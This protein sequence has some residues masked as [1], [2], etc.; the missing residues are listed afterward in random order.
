MM[1]GP[2][3]AWASGVVVLAA[4]TI[5]SAG[6]MTHGF[7][8]YYAAAKLLVSGQLGPSAYDDRWF[9]AYVQ[10]VTHSNVREIF[11]PN[12]PPMSLMALPVAA[13]DAG[14]ARAAWLSGSL[15]AFAAAMWALMRWCA[16]TGRQLSIVTV[17]VMML[18]PAVFTNLRIGQGYLLVCALLV[19]AVICL[20]RGRDT[21]G[22]VLLGALLALKTSGGAL[23]VMLAARQRWRAIAFA[24]ITALAIAV[25]VTPWIDPQMWLV[26]PDHVRAYVAR[27]ASS[28]TAYQTTL[29]L[30]R[31]VCVADP[32]WNP[33]P[34]ASCAPVAFIIPTLMVGAATLATAIAAYRSRST[35]AWLAAGAVLSVLTLPA[36]AEPHFVLMAIPL[37]LLALG[38]I[39]FAVVATLL[40]V[41]LEFTA[42]RF[43]AGWSVLLAYPRLYAAWLL[44]AACVKELLRTAGR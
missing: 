26:Y 18:S 7:V 20:G 27:P 24:A 23:V 41:P 33:S 30:F 38:P 5:Y 32:E 17:L 37:A 12:P 6:S 34:A 31:R 15:L 39:E 3:I 42:E 16:A 14:Q 21:A 9:G 2:R 8:S 11:I 19:S 35:E 10:R 40:V 13:L 28:V 1:R 29:S 44:W 43:T 25:I 4:F 22:G 36:V